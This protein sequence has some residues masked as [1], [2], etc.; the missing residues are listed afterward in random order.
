[1]HFSAAGR[2]TLVAALLLS[3]GAGCAEQHAVVPSVPAATEPAGAAAQAPPTAQ[4]VLP[5]PRVGAVFLGAG[6]LHTC[7]GGVLD[8][9]AGDLI[10]TAAHCLAAGTDTTFVAGLKDSAAPE[11]IWHVDA[12]YLDPRWMQNQDPMADFAIARVSRDAGGSVEAQAGGG[13]KVAPAPK[14]GT[15]VSVSGY[16]MGVGGGPVGCRTPT[17]ADRKGFPAVDCAELVDG[18]SG[19]PWIEGSS[20]VGVIG[21]LNG[22]GC[23][24]ESIS[25]SPPFGDVVKQLLVRA[26][27]GGPADAAPTA[28]DDQCG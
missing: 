5:D 15:V 13:L 3:L 10:I 21:G 27:A 24:N 12:F 14:P 20:V 28:F 8:S 6:T 4:P 26:E 7:T 16:G 11:D 23:A 9:A 1:M 22:G 18:L 19:A 17:V 25:Y 2:A